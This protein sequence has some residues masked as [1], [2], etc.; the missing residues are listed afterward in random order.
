[1]DI[2]KCL[3]N[4]IRNLRK[5]QDMSQEALAEALGIRIPSLSA[6]ERGRSFASYNTIVN[7]CS[8][9]HIQPKELFDFADI[10]LD[11]EQQELIYEINSI[12]PELE[13]EKLYYLSKIARLFT[14]KE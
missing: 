3:G 13:K 11:L 6:L 8:V 5:Q 12:L 4:K 9:F 14:N 2:K 1:M 10:T 7:L